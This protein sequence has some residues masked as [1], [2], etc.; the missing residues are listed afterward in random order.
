MTSIAFMFIL[1]GS[2]LLLFRR[3]LSLL[4]PIKGKFSSLITTIKFKD[5]HGA[6][7]K[8]DGQIL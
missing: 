6:D 3:I 1:D 5:S 2:L 4:S 8:E 7:L